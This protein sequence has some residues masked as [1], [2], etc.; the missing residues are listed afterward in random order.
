MSPVASTLDP[1]GPVA[2]AAADLWW[3]VLWLGT[4]V[5]VIVM[6]GA[7]KAWIQAHREGIGVAKCTVAAA[8][9]GPGAE[10]RHPGQSLREDHQTRSGPCPAR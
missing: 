4:A 6:Y 3:L 7:R 8:D 1:Q 10:G 2:S 5:F 9:A